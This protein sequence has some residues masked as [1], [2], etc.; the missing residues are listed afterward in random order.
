MPRVKLTKTIVAGAQPGETDIELRD[1]LVPG[2]FCKV[3]PTGRKV[4]MLQYRTT[5]G[6]RRKPSLGLFGELTVEQ[7]R[8]LAQ[9][10][11]A[12]VRRGNDP[13]GQKARDRQAPTVKDL[14]KRFMEDHCIPHNKPLTQKKNQYHIDK[15]LLPSMG[16]LKVHEVERADILALMKRLEKTP[17]QANRILACVRKMFNLAELWGYRP[18]GTNPCRHVTKFPEAKLD[19]LPTRR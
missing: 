9:D 1:T 13:S 18:D 12:D 14:C 6:K 15:Y 3:T 2:F 19:Y 5:S 8:T 17:T 4:F 11:L 7:A 10:L 16:T